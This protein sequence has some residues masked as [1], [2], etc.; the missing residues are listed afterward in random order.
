MLA[1]AGWLMLAGWRWLVL[2]YA[3][4]GHRGRNGGSSAAINALFTYIYA[5]MNL[6]CA[7][8][9]LL[10]WFVCVLEERAIIG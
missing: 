5:V 9:S 6:N 2:T 3:A 4:A 1:R 10:N 8:S 7:G